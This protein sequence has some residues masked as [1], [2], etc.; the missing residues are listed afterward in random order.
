MKPNINISGAKETIKKF[1]GA[2]REMV[3]FIKDSKKVFDELCP[4]CKRMVIVKTKARRPI[5]E[6]HYC[7]ECRRKQ[8]EMFGGKYGS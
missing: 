4:R 6:R 1:K 3:S 7:E 2:K 5:R 8:K